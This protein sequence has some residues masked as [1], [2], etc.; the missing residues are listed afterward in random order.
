VWFLAVY[1]LIALL[2]QMAVL[3]Q[4]NL[5]SLLVALVFPVI[6]AA[7]YYPRW[8]YLAA[9]GVVSVCAVWAT[10][11][12]ARYPSVWLAVVAG[13]IIVL[14]AVA[15]LVQRISFARVRIAA[16]LR[17]AQERLEH[18]SAQGPAIF[19]ATRAEGNFETIYISDNVEAI[20][21]YPPERFVHN[22]D[23]SWWAGIH[24]DDLPGVRAALHAAPERD[25]YAMEY[26]FRHADG[27]Y[28]W[29]R[30]E[31]RL[32]RDADGRPLERVGLW[33]DI[34]EQKRTQAGLLESRSNLTALVENTLDSI[35]SVDRDY[36]LIISNSAFR[37]VLRAYLGRELPVGESLLDEGFSEEI[38]RAWQA[39]Y[40]RAL[41]GER[42][43]E[44]MSLPSP[45][46]EIVLENSFNPI[47]GAPG[48]VTGVSVISRNI[49]ERRRM[50]ADL[51]HQRDFALQVV[52]TMGQGLALLDAQ[53][54]FEHVN[55][56]YARML[57]VPAEAL[58][59]QSPLE[60]VAAADQPVWR[61]KLA[62]CLAG[63]TLTFE[64]ALRR[65]DEGLMHGLINVVPRW[66]DGA[67]IGVISVTSNLTER[68]RIEAELQHQRDFA[69]QVMD[70][71]GQGLT[72]TDEAGRFEY[73]N[74]AYAD[75]LGTTPNRLLGLSQKDVT[76]AQDQGRLAE[77]LQLRR[78]GQPSTYETRLARFDGGVVYAL[79]TGVPRWR[80][81]A[82]AGSIAVVTDLTERRRLE[83][84]IREREANY[85]Q[86]FA[87]AQ[88]QTRELTLIDQAR[89]AITAELG[90][91]GVFRNMVEA[92][93]QTFGYPLVSAYLLEGADFVL[94]HQVGYGDVVD[95]IPVDRG[96]VGRVARS[97][98]SVL[99]QDVSRDPDFIAA[100]PN[101]QSE[102]CVP[103]LDHDEVVG[104]LNVETL[105]P[106]EL[107]EADRQLL[108]SLS[109][110]ISIAVRQ[111]RLYE[112]LRQKNEALAAANARLEQ[113]IQNA[114][115]LA[116]AAEAANRAKGD[117]LANM[118]HEIRTPMNAVLGM[119]ELLLET[120]LTQT[121]REYARISQEAAQALLTL[122][123]DVLDLSKIEAGRMALESRE[124][125]LAA[126][127]EGAADLLRARAREK[128][129]ALQVFVAPDLPRVVRGDAIRLRQ[130]LI[131][132]ISNAVKF[133]ER[134][135]VS[136]Q[137]ALERLA[138][139]QVEV[140]FTVQ[141]SGI[142]IAPE[143]QPRL[144]QP[145]TQA[146]ASTTRKYGGTGLGLVIARHL[147]ELM[148]GQILLTS[149]VG[150]GST[151]RFSVPFDM[152]PAPDEPAASSPATGLPPATSALE[153]APLVLLAE[154]NPANQRLA[155]LQLEKLGYRT[156]LA[157]NG[158]HALEAYAENPEAFS[159]ILMDCQ[160]PEMDG[161]QAARAIREM[162]AP[163]RRRI[164]I[165]AMTAN[166]MQGD[167]EAC[168]AAG[169]DDYVPKPVRGQVLHEALERWARRAPGSPP[170]RSPNVVL[171]RLQDR[172]A[173][174]KEDNGP[175]AMSAIVDLFLN[176]G[177][178]L[179]QRMKAAL[180]HG[181]AAGLYQAAHALKGS[182]ASLGALELATM[183]KL[184]EEAGRSGQTAF[185]EDTLEQTQSEYERVKSHLLELRRR[186]PGE[187]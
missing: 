165:I 14:A 157:D 82:P 50:E 41:R 2:L 105:A 22:A 79:I 72:V 9:L 26:R 37:E 54:R 180:Q 40:D 85:R 11:A 154:D 27:D 151:F 84:E 1:G 182:S 179:L 23:A 183:C 145:F 58:I 38:R 152:T 143:V 120:P 114:N 141:D 127:V 184:L 132:L 128:S 96:V 146:D 167:R 90:L 138:P 20:F 86:L 101:L 177:Q 164:P 116:V 91:P 122:I 46:G 93:A 5:Q 19:Y 73:V 113:A 45:N 103:I 166:A 63:E 60:F 153:A 55:P 187:H 34:T 98:Q 135:G 8:V 29:T 140:R 17:R 24:P 111:T 142:G 10:L 44:V 76:H 185:L 139:G 131:N 53:G 81:G 92:V 66:R 67:I 42:F 109:Q 71:L 160:M 115:E 156:R 147:V 100:I 28:R 77:A 108:V 25:H 176:N 70:T 49:T 117:F 136:V 134:G 74:P 68:K 104:V 99:I 95:R 106:W 65:S 174:L 97:R 21:G 89:S 43:S 119:T 16:E 178:H 107:Q 88:R 125:S 15:E 12:T 144:F 83:D 51:Q 161:F 48:Q 31:A 123:N 186:H 130:V 36:R 30:S 78:A 62:H 129:L 87:A 159:A 112:E 169:M 170:A 162:E 64:A 137:A 7:V 173:D 172:L 155:Q 175:E 133:T 18:L 6:L 56:A 158:R 57:G 102:V 59:G 149:V 61:E 124:F 171:Q 35:W 110:H 32:A 94:Q 4:A 39:C 75:M 33:L 163:T 3:T 52:N 47:L 126:V 69:R 80:N 13:L 168:L 121:Q 118:S 148:G 150:Q 181:D